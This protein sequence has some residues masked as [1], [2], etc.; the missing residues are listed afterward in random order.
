[1]RILIAILFC[2]FAGQASA[3]PDPDSGNFML[4]RCKAL[5]HNK[6]D[7][8]SVYSGVCGGVIST[9]VW[10]SEMFRDP[11]KFCAP[12]TVTNGQSSLVVV[13][14]ME[15]HP[16]LLHLP[17]VKLALDAMKEAWPCR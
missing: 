3:Q 4:P 5:V 1:M 2:T 15:N 13:R 17:F 14:Y 11:A 7:E 12:S 6:K 9:L 8:M 16:E 10:S